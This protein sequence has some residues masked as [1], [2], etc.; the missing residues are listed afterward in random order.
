MAKVP[1]PCKRTVKFKVGRVM[2]LRLE[3]VPVN[4]DGATGLAVEGS[5]QRVSKTS[6]SRE[7][8]G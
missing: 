3:E 4:I 6:M 1:V 2:K 8:T 5:A 7:K